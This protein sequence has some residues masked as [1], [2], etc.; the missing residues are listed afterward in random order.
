MSSTEQ[1]PDRWDLCVRIQKIEKILA[2]ARE[3]FI[4]G[5]EWD[6]RENMKTAKRQLDDVM[7]R[8]GR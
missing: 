2:E 7:E 5:H 8:V 3:L 6:G 1:S 4:R